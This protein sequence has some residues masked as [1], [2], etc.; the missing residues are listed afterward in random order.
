M[1]TVSIVVSIT[2]AGI[3]A[4]AL[5]TSCDGTTGYD[6]EGAPLRPSPVAQAAP[7]APDKPRPPRPARPA[8][9][10][11][12]GPKKP[13]SKPGPMPAP[14]HHHDHHDCDDD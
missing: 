11:K 10:P 13:R 3:L 8:S 14:T 2:A 7:M 4:A 6:C 1:R 9:K 12:P 5:L